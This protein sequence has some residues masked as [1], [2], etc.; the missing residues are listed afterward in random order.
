[1]K[2]RPDLHQVLQVLAD[3]LVAESAP[4]VATVLRAHGSTPLEIGAKAVINSGGLI[5]VPSAAALSRAK[6]CDA[7]PW[8]AS[9]AALIYL[10][11]R[12]MVRAEPIRARSAAA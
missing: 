3:P 2:S 12:F 11:F 5:A 10:C 9:N 4:V 7:R 6:L 8:C 1:M